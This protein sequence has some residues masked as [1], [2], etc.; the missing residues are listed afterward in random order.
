MNPLTLRLSGFLFIVAA[1]V[2]SVL[3]LHRVADLRMPWL[4]PVLLVIGAALVIASR[5]RKGEA[6]L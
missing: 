2:A 3:N 6:G 1:V 4:A 5:R